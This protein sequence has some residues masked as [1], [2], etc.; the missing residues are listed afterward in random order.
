MTAIPDFKLPT[1]KNFSYVGIS[2][3]CKLQYIYTV[4][5]LADFMDFIGNTVFLGYSII[6]SIWYIKPDLH[7]CYFTAHFV[8]PF[9][10][11]FW[12][13]RVKIKTVTSII[14]LFHVFVAK[15]FHGIKV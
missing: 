5:V 12:A 3:R 6:Q 13:A 4:G 9:V 15:V 10:Q 2:S 7:M 1:S 14:S 8:I 11:M